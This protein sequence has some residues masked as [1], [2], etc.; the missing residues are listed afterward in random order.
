MELPSARLVFV[1][2]AQHGDVAR[3]RG[4]WRSALSVPMSP[5]PWGTLT[6]A[7]NPSSQSWVP[8][9]TKHSEEAG[10]ACGRIS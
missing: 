1:G 6:R 3:S 2:T 4:V 10:P 5:G 7:N 8:A 9:E